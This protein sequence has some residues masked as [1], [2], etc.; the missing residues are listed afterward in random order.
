M[1]RKLTAKQVEVLRLLSEGYSSQE[2]A[3][4]LENSKKTID[5]IRNQ[6]LIITDS[7]NVAQLISWGFKNGVLSTNK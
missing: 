1:S 4:K 5:N 7:K 6:A 3:V 2:I